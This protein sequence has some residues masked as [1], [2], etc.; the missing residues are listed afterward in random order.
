MKNAFEIRLN[1]LIRAFVR[2]FDKLVENFKNYKAVAQ[3][4]IDCLEVMIKVKDDKIKEQQ[5]SVEEY[6]LALK[7]P[8]LHYKHLEKLRFAE[9]MQQLVIGV[10]VSALGSFFP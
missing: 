8:R 9:I 6:E 10:S 7:I 2:T 4:E 3:R 5:E 1:T